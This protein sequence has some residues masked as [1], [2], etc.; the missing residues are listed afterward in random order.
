ML[1]LI[2][3]LRLSK[4]VIMNLLNNEVYQKYVNYVYNL[5]PNEKAIEYLIELSS[6]FKIGVIP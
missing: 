2:Q 4:N 5:T 3:Q 6:A 1:L